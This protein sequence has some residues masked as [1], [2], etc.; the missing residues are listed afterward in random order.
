MGTFTDIFVEP[1]AGVVNTAGATLVG[2][3]QPAGIIDAAGGMLVGVK[4]QAGVVGSVVLGFAASPAH[5]CRRT[6]GRHTSVTRV[7]RH[8]R[9][10]SACVCAAR[11]VH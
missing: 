5:L 1:P 7:R 4:P 9:R 11:G 8:L 10:V 6:P 3:Q 2:I